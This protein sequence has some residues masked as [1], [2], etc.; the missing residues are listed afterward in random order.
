MMRGRGHGCRVLRVSGERDSLGGCQGRRVVLVRARGFSAEGV[1]D[2]HTRL[3]LADRALAWRLV[4]IDVMLECALRASSGTA[5]RVIRVQVVRRRL[6]I[7][8][9]LGS[10][11]VEIR[12]YT[13]WTGQ[14]AGYSGRP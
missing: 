4:T 14:V 2:T 9:Y 7:M 10:T 6:A 12:V 11:A 8:A 5:S 3:P 1:E 13:G